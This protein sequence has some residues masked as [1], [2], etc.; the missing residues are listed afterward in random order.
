M[1]DRSKLALLTGASAGIGEA[2]A[3][4]IAADGYDLVLVA[5]RA[6][7][8]EAD[9]LVTGIPRTRS[10]LA[11]FADTTAERLA[12]GSL[13]PVLLASLAAETP[14]TEALC[15][16]SRPSR[17]CRPASATRGWWPSHRPCGGGPR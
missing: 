9:L 14:W 17:C 10:L 15:R 1:P 6:E 2:L 8:L 5:R 11:T 4:R 16:G 3:H 12:R 7:R 13:R